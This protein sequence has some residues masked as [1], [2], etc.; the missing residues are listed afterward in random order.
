M[1]APSFTGSGGDV[2]TGNVTTVSVQIPPASFND[3]DSITIVMGSDPVS[4]TFTPPT[5]FSAQYA[6]FDIPTSTPTATGIVM[7]KTNVVNASET[8]NGTN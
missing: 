6:A 7:R 8:F 3:G 2:N 4:Q 5:G 1:T